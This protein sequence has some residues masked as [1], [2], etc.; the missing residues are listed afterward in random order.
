MLKY[1]LKYEILCYILIIAF[2]KYKYSS[3]KLNTI[4]EKMSKICNNAYIGL[5]E[6]SYKISILELK[7]VE[8]LEKWLRIIGRK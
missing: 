8:L 4:G 2:G 6:K 5:F 3:Y 1:H 7:E